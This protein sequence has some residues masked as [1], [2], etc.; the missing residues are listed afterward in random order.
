MLIS[1]FNDKFINQTNTLHFFA[2]L[3]SLGFGACAIYCAMEPA[4]D[5]WPCIMGGA[6]F[7]G[8]CIDFF[9]VS[10]YSPKLP[11]SGTFFL[12]RPAGTGLEP[13]LRRWRVLPFF[14]VGQ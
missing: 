9:F 12:F 13:D 3:A 5:G 7:S 14:S 1:C 11:R 2:I 4:T 8:P 10:L 6:L